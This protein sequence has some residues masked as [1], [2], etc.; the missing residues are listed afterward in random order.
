MAYQ[1][2][3]LIAEVLIYNETCYLHSQ[4]YIVTQIYIQI[5]IVRQLDQVK[6]Q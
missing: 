6:N 2:A 5:Y 1:P 4:I 3:N